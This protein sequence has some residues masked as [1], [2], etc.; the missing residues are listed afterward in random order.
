MFQVFFDSG[1]GGGCVRA[2]WILRA[3]QSKI[4]AGTY[5]LYLV[6]STLV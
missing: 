1:C 6:S 5:L 2:P 3:H 4:I